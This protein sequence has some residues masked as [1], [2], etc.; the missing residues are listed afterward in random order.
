MVHLIRSRTD[1]T[2]PQIAKLIFAEVYK[3]HGL[4]QN[5]ISDCDVLFTSNFWMALHELL[6]VKLSMSSAYHPETDGMTER[7]NRT[8]TQM[9]QKLHKHR[10]EGWG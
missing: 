5:I 6:G 1:Y 2:A 9:I 7:A 4:P 3:Q 8:I 10:S